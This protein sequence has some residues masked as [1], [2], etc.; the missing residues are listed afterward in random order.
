MKKILF[1]ILMLVP[2]IIIAQPDFSKG[3]SINN[4]TYSLPLTYGTTGQ[5]LYSVG[6]TGT[7][8]WTSAVGAT[9]STGVTGVTGATGANGVTGATGS[10]GAV[11]A[12][13]ITGAT[14]AVGATGATGVF[15]G[16]AWLTT[17]NTGATGSGAYYIGT[18]DNVSFIIKTN[19]IFAVA[20]D[21]SN[22]RVGINERLPKAMLEVKEAA[23][24]YSGTVPVAYF[25]GGNKLN[26]AVV[27]DATFAGSIA[28]PSENI[29]IYGTADGHTAGHN[30]AGYF[31]AGNVYMANNLGINT[32]TPL[33]KLQVSGGGTMSDYYT[34]IYNKKMHDNADDTLFS[35]VISTDSAMTAVVNFG[36][37]N[38][39]N[40]DRQ[41]RSGT[42]NIS[43]C[44]KVGSESGYQ[45]TSS[46][47]E[48]LTS[49]TLAETL[50]VN[51]V[52]AT[53]TIYV[54]VKYNSSLS[55]TSADTFL[56]FT[57]VNIT[58]V[59]TTLTFYNYNY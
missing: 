7:V 57:I 40:T 8:G 53:S 26:I 48:H 30:Y 3:I 28:L 11:G 2:F 10:N 59:K 16:S 19:N 44:I 52:Q 6:A 36:Y 27:G 51:Y 55:V 39:D 54:I 15:S 35:F 14:G 58:G 29:G 24:V 1:A 12:T 4:H 25:G 42:Y 20:V 23:S 9:G 13:G 22:G 32:L 49:G 45:F 41:S 38:N 21:S 31:G 18:N 50:S 17:G 5:V 34:T 37:R 33:E 43:T 46:A 47:V 56:N